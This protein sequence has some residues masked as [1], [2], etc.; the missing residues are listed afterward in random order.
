GVSGSVV[1][2][3]G[4]GRSN[5][6]RFLCEQPSALQRYMPDA[7]DAVALIPIELYDLPSDNLAHLYRTMLHAV[8]CVR[9]RLAPPLAQAATDLYREPRAAA[10]PFLTQTALYELLLAFQVAGVR[11]VL[12]VNRFDRF[13]ETSTPQMVNTLRSLR[14]RFK[15][16]LS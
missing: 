8:Y 2:L 14:D 7:S 16:T 9:E 15:E 11:A 4:C 6:L 3:A 10:D 12:V 5:L 13:C 1:G